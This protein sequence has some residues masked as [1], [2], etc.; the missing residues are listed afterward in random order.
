MTVTCQCVGTKS[1]EQ[2]II[3]L[4]LSNA[5]GDIA[6]L[7]TDTDA[8]VDGA[9]TVALTE[10]PG[11]DDAVIFLRHIDNDGSESLSMG[12]GW[13]VYQ[14]GYVG[15]GYLTAPTSDAVDVA[16]TNVTPNGSYKAIDAAFVVKSVST[17]SSGGGTERTIDGTASA[18][19]LSTGALSRSRTLAG[20]ATAAS[21]IGDTPFSIT[22]SLGGSASGATLATGAL[23]R[24]AAL[25]GSS[26]AASGTAQTALAVLRA[27]SGQ[28]TASALHR[29]SLTTGSAIY[30]GYLRNLLDRGMEPVT[31]YLEEVAFDDDGNTWTRAKT[32]GIETMATVQVAAA[33]GT[34]SRR[35]EQDNEG[36]ETEENWRIRFPRQ[37]P[38]VLGAQ[39]K[40]EWRGLMYSIVGD[41]RRYNGSPRTAH[42]EYTIRRA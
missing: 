33:S 41:A 15:V 23:I 14:Q 25:T 24:S 5:N 18:A 16:D 32:E 20:N 7:V 34:S 40:V 11:S 29:G 22:R 30:G 8:P 19:S 2:Q 39:A 12:A 9:Y 35:S 27:L 3:V 38:Y 37:F 21:G 31:V 36:F 26:S 4:G 6:G 1:Y 17:E 13:T 10:S 42:I 28:A